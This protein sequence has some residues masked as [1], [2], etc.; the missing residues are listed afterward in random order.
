MNNYNKMTEG[1]GGTEKKNVE[2]IEENEKFNL[3]RAVFFILKE[4]G[5]E[6][7]VEDERGIYLSE[8]IPGFWIKI[9]WLGN[10]PPVLDVLKEM[11]LTE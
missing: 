6:R 1:E 11:E 3:K 4:R 10:P 2:K 5:Y 9:E 8:V 7:R